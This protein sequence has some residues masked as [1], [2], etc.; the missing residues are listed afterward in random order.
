MKIII[1]LSAICF[2]LS[3][4]YPP[5][6]TFFA[7]SKCRDTMRFITNEIPRLLQH[8]SRHL[9][10]RNLKVV[11]AGKTVELPDSAE[12]SR[13]FECTYGKD[14]CYG[15]L[16][17]NSYQSITD[18]NEWDFYQCVGPKVIDQFDTGYVNFNIIANLCTP[19]NID[20]IRLLAI[21]NDKTKGPEYYHDAVISTPDV[22]GYVPYFYFDD[23][24]KMEFN[25]EIQKDSVAFLCKYTHN[26]GKVPG[27]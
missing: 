25:D 2:S 10:F 17:F 7:Q 20:F 26:Q 14:E 1:F 13:K 9:L 12:G 15:N 18:L 19:R 4:V 27:C 3:V 6:I 16:L 21:A 5:D 23:V 11:W 22:H 8:E 24:H